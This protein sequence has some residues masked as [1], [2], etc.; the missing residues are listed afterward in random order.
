VLAA[1][2][3][4]IGWAFLP[5]RAVAAPPAERDAADPTAAIKGFV[6]EP[7]LRLELVASEPLVESPCALAFDARGRMFVAENRGYPI[8][9]ADGEPPLG[10]IAM[11]EDRDGDGTYDTRTE[12]AAGLTFP[13]G[14]MPWRDGLLVTCA[15]EV[16]YLADT[17]GDG[18]ADVRRVVL[19]GFSTAGST[20]LRGS[21]PTLAID[22]WVYITSGLT[23]GKISSP[24]MPEQPPVE[25][26]RTDVRFQPDTGKIEPADG[27]S[28]F[29]LSFDDFGRRFICYNR[30]HVQHVVLASGWLRRNPHLPFSDTVENCPAEML[31]EPS[32][33]HGRSA[34]LF[35]LS[36]NVTTADS[37]AGTFTAAC[38][39]TIYRGTAL[40]PA[41]RGGVFSCDPT[42]NLV[43]FDRLEPRGATFSAVRAAAGR[44]VLATADD[45]FRPVFLAGGPDGALYICDMHRKTIEHPDYL[46]AEIRKH[47]DFESGRNT[48]RIYRLVGDP[49]HREQLRALRRVDIQ[50]ASPVQLC[51]TLRDADGWWQDTAHRLLVE[52]HGKTPD[53]ATV[54]RLKNFLMTG[55]PNSTAACVHALRLLELSGQIDDT[56]LAHVLA[57]GAAPVREHAI[58]IA[59]PRLRDWP[60]GEE[61]VV[62]AAG[63]A[64]LRVR[65]YAALAL[66][67]L[68]GDRDP[69]PIAKIALAGAEDRWTRAAAL[70]SIAGRE[71]QFLD[72]I[73]LQAGPAKS[74]QSELFYELGRVLGAGQPAEA[75]PKAMARVTT[76]WAAAPPEQQIPL[77]T[78]IADGLRRKSHES[79]NLLEDVAGDSAAVDPAVVAAIRQ[80]MVGAIR[81]A[82]DAE[83]SVERR[84]WCTA[85]LAYSDFKSAGQTLL[86]LVEPGQPDVLQAAAVRSLIGMSDD[87]VVVAL[88]GHDKFRRYTPRLREEVLQALT[89]ATHHVPGL[90]AALESGAVNPADLDLSLRRQLTENRDAA[91]RARAGKLWGSADTGDR[92]KVFEDLKGVVE[93]TP[94]AENGWRVF[95]RTC[96][97]CLRLDRQGF[98][99]GPDLFGIRNQPKETI[100]L[101]IL[102][103]DREI[104]TGFAAYSVL[105]KDGRALSGLVASETP[106]S[107]TLRQPLGKEEV[108]LKQDIEELTAISTSLMPQGIERTVSRQEFADLLAYLKGEWLGA[109]D[110]DAKSPITVPGSRE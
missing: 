94:D 59:A 37:H 18:H 64:D 38:G 1:A 100:L 11:L 25:V 44:E 92:A 70:S 78:G 34:Q 55:Q 72:A 48:G 60:V 69:S 109:G 2:A 10:R 58:Q 93:L 74:G 12:F 42:A 99:V 103:P 85:L 9:P 80:I 96:A 97:Q 31:P 36:H 65:F 88:L 45:W 66:G 86:G 62:A 13:N 17:D 19:T 20:Q 102:I 54:E 95:G 56:L 29:G 77:L 41:Y 46:P 47:T 75:W 98:A 21:H 76:G 51:E 105:T 107:I 52:R 7:G 73:I 106:T 24:L 91:I 22:N 15:P 79:T 108:L 90:L 63:D 61:L 57:Q 101:H 84:R 35:P 8:G 87:A 3:G 49:S 50:I 16:L 67:D 4:L 81:T 110:A 53:R 68:S 71:M 23:G 32:K 82:A 30:V 28:Q 14:L 40:P 104:T 43:H 83:Q 39:V 5:A 33:G 89:S 6:V 26:G 27:G